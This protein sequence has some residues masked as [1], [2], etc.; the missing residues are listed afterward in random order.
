[1][2]NWKDAKG[3]MA[4]DL[5]PIDMSLVKPY[6]AS[7]WVAALAGLADDPADFDTYMRIHNTIVNYELQLMVMRDEIRKIAE[8]AE[9]DGAKHIATQLRKVVGSE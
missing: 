1:M 7:E 2:A 6:K 8:H 5:Y 3:I 4:S 9:I